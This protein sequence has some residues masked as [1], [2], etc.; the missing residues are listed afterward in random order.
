MS[1]GG[2]KGRRHHSTATTHSHFTCV[3]SSTHSLLLTLLSTNPGSRRSVAH[4]L[5]TADGH[6]RA[7]AAQQQQHCKHTGRGDESGNLLVLVTGSGVF[8]KQK[9]DTW[10]GCE[11]RCLSSVWCCLWACFEQAQ[12]REAATQPLSHLTHATHLPLQ[13]LLSAPF[14]SH[15]HF[16]LHT[17]PP[18]THT[19][20]QGAVS[21][22]LSVQQ[23]HQQGAQRQQQHQ[24]RPT[25][26]HSRFKQ[27]Q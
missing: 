21:L 9:K 1:R 6:C 3:C 17:P 8:S 24:Q 2:S 23:Q 5:Y 7:E 26:P 16:H 4:H 20:G 15:P 27:H 11:K 25:T 19:G 22:R 12:L 10:W 18:H 14:C 13:L